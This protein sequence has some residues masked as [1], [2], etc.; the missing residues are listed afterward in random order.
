MADLVVDAS[1]R[2]SILPRWLGRLPGGLGS[3]VDETVMESGTQYVSRWF[4]L[5]PGDA[6]DWH[7]LSVA[8]AAGA[9][10]RCAHDAARG[11]GLLGRRSPG[12]GRRTAAIR[13]HGLPGLHRWPRRWQTS[14]GAC[15]GEARVP[16]PSLR[17]RRQSHEAL[18]SPDRLACGAGRPRRLGMRA[19]SVLRAGHDGR[20]HGVRCS[21]GG[22]WTRKPAGSY[23]AVEFQKELASL[24]AQPWRL[25]TGREADGQP[26][27]RDEPY[28]CRLYEAAPSSPEIAHALLA[29]QH[30]L[31]PVETLMEIHPI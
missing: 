6:P 18:R 13:R 2:G 22:A 24:N 26:L 9:P 23:P 11:G 16:H 1:G 17:P 12:S 21:S 19:R 28:L 15:P 27:A 30:L 10:P 4:H 29:V 8:P 14:R 25:A 3:H 7:C 5:E 31:R 20:P